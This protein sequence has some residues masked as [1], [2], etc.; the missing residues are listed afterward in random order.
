MASG[1]PVV[2]SSLAGIPEIIVDQINGILVP[3][4]AP[5]ALASAIRSLL[6]DPKKRESLGASGLNTVREKFN[7][8][9]TVQ[10]LIGIFESHVS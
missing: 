4:Q 9:T 8:A 7:L 5:E 10:E 1:L 2:S 3:Q 6:L